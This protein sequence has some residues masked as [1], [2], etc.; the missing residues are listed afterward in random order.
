VDVERDAIAAVPVPTRLPH[1]GRVL[2]RTQA[3]LVDDVVQRVD[4]L[5]C[6]LG[7][8]LLEVH[9]ADVG[10]LPGVHGGDD[11][12][13]KLLPPHRVLLD[14]DPV[15]AVVERCHEA[16]HGGAV[17]SGEAVPER[18]GDWRGGVALSE[19]R[20]GG[21]L[22]R[23]AAAPRNGQAGDTGRD[24][25]LTARQRHRPAVPQRGCFAQVS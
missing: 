10:P 4:G 16:P 14:H 18:D 17:A 12:L 6:G 1:T 21:R 5:P 2:L 9:G 20:S 13:V 11:P 7:A 25:E 22:D 23:R 15:L 8:Q 3:Q 24:E 19:R